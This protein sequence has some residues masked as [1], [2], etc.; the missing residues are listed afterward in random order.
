MRIRSLRSAATA[1]CAL[2]LLTGCIEPPELTLLRRTQEPRVLAGTASAERFWRKADAIAQAYKAPAAER[3]RIARMA[4]IGRRADRGQISLQAYQA[5][6]AAALA[7][8]E[9]QRK[10]ARRDASR[11]WSRVFGGGEA[12]APVRLVRVD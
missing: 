12:R 7:R 10:A 3:A 8:Y 9:A 4:E 2:I 1:L 6:H 11:M 5:H